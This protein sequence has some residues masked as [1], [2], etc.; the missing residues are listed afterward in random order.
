MQNGFLE[1]KL[2][3]GKQN[4]GITIQERRDESTKGGI[5]HA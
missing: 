4:A 3:K 2:P 1:Q 5:F